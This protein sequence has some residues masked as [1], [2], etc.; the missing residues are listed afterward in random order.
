VSSA[1]G[2]NTYATLSGTSM[3]SPAVTGAVTLMR[4]YLTEGW[5]PTGAPVPADGFAPS[6]ALLK[7][8]AINSADN[9]VTDYSVPD[10]NVG[11]GRVDADNVLYFPGDARR[12]LVMDR[13]Q[14]LADGDYVD[15]PVNVTDASVPLKVTLVWSD[16]PGDPAAAL[17]LVNDLDLTVSKDATVYKGNVFSGGVSATGGAYDDRNVEEEVLVPAPALGVWTVRVAATAVPMGPQPFA[18]CVTGG[19]GAAAGALALDR[20]EYGSASTVE[21]Q[22]VDA[23]AGPTVSVS[24]ASTSEP[25]GESVTLTG[26]S[27]VFTGTLTLTPYLSGTGDGLL[28]VSDGDALTATYVDA[29]TSAALTAHAA[30][31]FDTPTIT[32][33][34]ATSPAAGTALVS[35]TTDRNAS[36]RVR[37]GLTP[38]LELGVADSAGAALEHRVLL[39]GLTPGATYSY[40]VESVGLTGSAARDSLGGAHHRLT[41]KQRGEVLLVYGESPFPRSFTW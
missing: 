20:Q 39:T 25:A 30:V 31:T 3:A 13:T 8:M 28:T 17:Q 27:G 9:A 29:T 26:G 38:A 24:V 33:V 4:E 12:L 19:V 14:G 40:D 5:Y 11:W 7:A 6:A 16:F 36:S 35:W 1:W 15:Y 41:V 18:L 34:T 37:Y 22:V 2:G 21:I 10:T 23:D 32:G